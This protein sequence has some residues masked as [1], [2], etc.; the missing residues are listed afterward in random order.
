[1]ADTEVTQT[2]TTSTA[3]ARKRRAPRKRT[4]TKTAAARKTSRRK[5]ATRTQSRSGARKRTS[6]SGKNAM[7]DMLRS[8]QKRAA[9][10]GSRIVK[11]SEESAQAAKKAMGTVTASSRKTIQGVKREWNRMDSKTKA[12]FVVALLGTLAAAS[13]SVVASRRRK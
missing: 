11:L 9:G 12:K 2:T 4:A 3:T 8:L 13:G 6:G 5:T 1:L 7:A 10:T